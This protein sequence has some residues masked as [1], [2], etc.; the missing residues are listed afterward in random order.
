MKR[1]NTA[2]SSRPITDFFKKPQTQPQSSHGPQLVPSASPNPALNETEDQ[3][4]NIRITSNVELKPSMDI[5]I[6]VNNRK[7]TDAEKLGLI[8]QKIPSVETLPY[9]NES[10]HKR[11]FQPGWCSTYPWLK[12]SATKNGGYCVACVLF[13]GET[14]GT[15]GQTKLGTFVLE[16]MVKFKKATELLCNHNKAAYHLTAMTR[17]EQ[18][19]YT[20]NHPTKAIDLIINRKRKEQIENNRRLLVPIIET[21]LFC[22]RNMLPLRG[23]RDDGPLNLNVPS[24]TGEG[25]FR[26]LLRYRTQGGDTD[27]RNLLTSSAR[28]TTMISKTIQDD[29]INI[30]GE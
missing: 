16:P 19:V 12:Y 20:A 17:M 4:D 28:N 7:T 23:H 11:R 29:L 30:A 5:A 24:V 21:V 18:F 13:A 1:K 2:C 15:G 22:G 26:A 6:F 27:L 10:G 25:V 9:I 14:A 3:L 8:N